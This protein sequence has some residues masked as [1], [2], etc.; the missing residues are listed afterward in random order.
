MAATGAPGGGALRQDAAD[1]VAAR[2]PPVF[3]LLLGPAGLWRVERQGRRRRGFDRSRRA[4]ENGLD[5]A[6]ADIQ[7]LKQRFGH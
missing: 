2:P 1:R 4:H 5:G 3:R 6:R 7:T